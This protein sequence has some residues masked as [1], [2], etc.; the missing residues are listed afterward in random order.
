MKIMATEP[1]HN[2]EQLMP[3]MLVFIDADIT[4]GKDE[5]AREQLLNNLRRYQSAGVSSL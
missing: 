5:I 3:P 1:A 4:S 2:N